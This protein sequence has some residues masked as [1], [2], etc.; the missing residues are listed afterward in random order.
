MPIYEY[1]CPECNSKFELL[2]SLSQANEDASCPKCQHAAKRIFSRF[3]SHSKFSASDYTAMAN[4]AS[5]CNGCAA[6]SC[7]SCHL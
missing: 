5:S 7:D 3:V 1:F 4:A 2:R 6:T